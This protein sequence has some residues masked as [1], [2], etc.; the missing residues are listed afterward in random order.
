MIK[1]EGQIVTE[2]YKYVITTPLAA[3]ITGK[4]LK[5]IDREPNSVSE[6]IV[7]KPL[8]NNPKQVQ[9]TIVNMNIYVPD[10]LDEGQYIKNGER[11]DQLEALACTD[12]EVFW[13]EGARIAL[14]EQHTYKVDDARCHVINCRLLYKIENQ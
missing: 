1:S 7:I 8:A 13:I 9:E 11:C 12:F 10:T 2:I 6:D 4:V 3:A 14:E 5:S